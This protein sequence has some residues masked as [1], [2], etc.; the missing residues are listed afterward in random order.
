[1]TSADSG[2]TTSRTP[3]ATS[4]LRIETCGRYTTTRVFAWSRPSARPIAAHVARPAVRLTTRTSTPVTSSR[5]ASCSS[6]SVSDW[7]DS[8]RSSR[9]SSRSWA[10]WVG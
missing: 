10:W 4:R 1:M 6:R 8:V 3:A 9:D 5:R 7:K 2:A